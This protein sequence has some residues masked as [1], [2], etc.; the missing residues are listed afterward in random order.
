MWWHASSISALSRLEDLCELKVSFFYIEF[1][2]NQP[3]REPVKGEGGGGG[4]GGGGGEK[5][6]K[7][8]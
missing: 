5:A 4:G 8:I 2:I 1:Q 6:V 3:Y 7:G